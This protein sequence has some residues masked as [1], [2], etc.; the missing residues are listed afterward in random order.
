[1]THLSICFSMLKQYKS[2]LH[3]IPFV[4]VPVVVD[5]LRQI[6]WPYSQTLGYT[7]NTHKHYWPFFLCRHCSTGLGCG[8][9]MLSGLFR[10]ANVGRGTINL[11]PQQ[12]SSPIPMLWDQPLWI[13]ATGGVEMRCLGEAFVFPL[14]LNCPSCPSAPGFPQEERQPSVERTQVDGT[15]FI[16]DSAS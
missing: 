1:M 13:R 16:C 6:K 3:S 8:L 5:S 14:V 7:T 2:T 12:R 4:N 10:S 15:F 11:L 9:T